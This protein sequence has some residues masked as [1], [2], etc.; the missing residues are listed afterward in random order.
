VGEAFEQT[1]VAMGGIAALGD[2][3]TGR[4]LHRLGVVDGRRFQKAIEEF[5]A[6]PDLN[7]AAWSSFWRALSAEAFLRWFV[8]FTRQ[9]ADRP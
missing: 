9:N 3:C 2:L 1:V 6:R 5:A 7:P 8:E 4:E